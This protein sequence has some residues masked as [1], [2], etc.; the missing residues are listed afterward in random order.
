MIAM[1]GL[2]VK[3]GVTLRMASSVFI[4]SA[5]SCKS[6]ASTVIAI[7]VGTSSPGINVAIGVL[8]AAVQLLRKTITNTSQERL[9]FIFGII[10]FWESIFSDMGSPLTRLYNV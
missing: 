9:I 4:V 1:V 3:V 8:T 10:D 5:V 6:F 2:G 7:M